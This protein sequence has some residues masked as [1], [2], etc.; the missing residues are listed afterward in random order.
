MS[1]RYHPGTDFK[2]T[3]SF[4]GRDR[5][6]SGHVPANWDGAS[7]LPLVV[8]IHGATSNPRLMQRFCGLSEKADSSSFL[9]IYPAGSGNLPNVLTWN[10]GDCCGYAVQHQVNDI[11]WL[12][13][14]LDDVTSAMPIDPQRIYFAGMSNGAHMT[15]RYAGHRS[16][17]IAAIACV[18]GPM[19]TTIDSLDRPVP[20]VHIHGTNDQFAPFEGGRGPLS[21]Y[22]DPL[23]SVSESIAT[24]V[25]LCG[26]PD[27]PRIETFPDIAGDGTTI[28]RSTY[29]SG[30]VILYRVENGGHTW[31]GQPP[32]P[33]SLG[34]SS[35]NLNAND[36]IWEF[37]QKHSL[38]NDE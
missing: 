30:E 20:L 3:R 11:G 19:A 15:F 4:E 14:V 9:V 12:D 25:R 17:R 24:W 10:G 16:K 8:A 5:W 13:C 18:A 28:V 7:P 26:L 1:D 22:R 37:F 36:V 27:T 35:S 38:G 33:L 32:L 31:P 21:L 6:Y 34:L 23:R 29:G 2:R